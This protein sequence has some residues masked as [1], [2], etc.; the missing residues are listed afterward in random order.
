LQDPAELTKR[1]NLQ[2]RRRSSPLAFVPEGFLVTPTSAGRGGSSRSGGLVHLVNGCRGDAEF[3]GDRLDGMMGGIEVY[4]T[5]GSEVRTNVALVVSLNF[6]AGQPVE[7][8][9]ALPL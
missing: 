5:V 3:G 8:P 7:Y 9:I 6:I 2:S 4:P 1:A